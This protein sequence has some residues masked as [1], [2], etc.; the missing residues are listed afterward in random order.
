MNAPGPVKPRANVSSAGRC[1]L[2]AAVL[3]GLASY[4]AVS[5]A[6][7]ILEIDTD[8]LDDG[9]LS[10]NPGFSF[11]GDTTAASSSAASAAY[12]ASGGDSIFGGDGLFDP[13]TYVY[14]YSPGTTPDNLVIPAGT[15][16]GGGLLAS[17]LAGGGAGT[18]R[19]YATWPF[20][21]NVSGGDTRYT[22]S[23]GGAPDLVVEVDQNNLGDEWILLGDISYTDLLAPITVTQES[24]SN[25]FVSMRA[26]GLLFEQITPRATIP[27]P[28]TF[29]LFGLG[30]AVLVFRERRRIRG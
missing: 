9:A 16:L 15:D 5:R 24:Q 12:G 6:A 2:Y 18:Y 21:T 25:T 29:A 20:T 7:F 1:L 11:G 30:L 13:D 26:Y 22:I 27:E 3:T 17:G 10:Y 28:S 19:V 8:G 4:S 14:S 23:T